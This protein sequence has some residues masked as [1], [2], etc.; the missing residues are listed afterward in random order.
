MGKQ[1]SLKK[2]KKQEDRVVGVG[3]NR[4]TCTPLEASLGQECH[5][6]NVGKVTEKKETS[7]GV[8][9]RE[10]T[11]SRSNTQRQHQEKNS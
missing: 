9:A 5:L 1:N 11:V 7:G 8:S 2:K 6:R 4:T 3:T 10:S